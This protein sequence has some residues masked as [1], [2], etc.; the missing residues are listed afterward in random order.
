MAARCTQRQVDNR[1]LGASTEP[2]PVKSCYFL[3]KLLLGSAVFM[4]F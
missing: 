1:A 2:P 3:A 4:I